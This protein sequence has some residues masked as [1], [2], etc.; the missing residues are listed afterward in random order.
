MKKIFSPII[1]LCLL[2]SLCTL[3]ASAAAETAVAGDP[4][5]VTL[6]VDGSI[7]RLWAYNIGGNNYFKLRDMAYLLKDT[8]ACFSVEWNEAANS[9]N[10]VPGGTYRTDGSERTAPNKGVHVIVPS[11]QTVLLSGYDTDG[12]VYNIDGSNYFKLRD[13]M[14]D[15]DVGVTYDAATGQ[16]GL[17]TAASYDAGAAFPAPGS[18]LL[19]MEDVAKRSASTLTL[20]LL[21]SNGETVVSASGA[22][23]RSDG[24]IACC[25][26]PLTNGDE[27]ATIEAVTESGK[28]YH[29]STILAYDK[30]AD[31]AVIKADG[32]NNAV[33]I[34]IGDSDALVPG[35]SIAII[36]APYSIRNTLSN[37][38]VS[39]IRD[40]SEQLRSEGMT[41]IQITAPMSSGNSGGP[42]LDMHGNLVGLVYCMHRRAACMGFCVSSNEVSE[43]LANLSDPLT[44]P[45]FLNAALGMELS[46]DDGSEDADSDSEDSEKEH[47]SNS[48]E[49][50]TD[51][52]A[53]SDLVLT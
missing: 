18:A 5:Q 14:A 46:S 23:V 29:V 32:V 9:V 3:P 22:F 42:L 7:Q 13:I 36:G 31:I 50:G 25:C 38:I 21:D 48:A 44:I 47:S 24:I 6:L 35:Q 27:Y 8:Q 33:P 16:I 4:V 43:M 39:A 53:V 11:S 10:I 19:S 41:D 26:H 20:Y 49:T 12:M 45:E 1:V 28:T 37:G 30:D 2:V 40:G 34:P 17:D 52:Y 51:D 15:V